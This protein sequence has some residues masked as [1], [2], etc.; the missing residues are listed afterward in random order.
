[1]GVPRRVDVGKT[2]ADVPE[3]AEA[4]RRYDIRSFAAIVVPGTCQGSIQWLCLYQPERELRATDE[5][6]IWLSHFTRHMA[7]ALRVNQIV[8]APPRPWSSDEGVAAVEASTGKLIRADDTFLKSVMDEWL[9]FDGLVLPP[10]V[11]KLWNTVNHKFVFIGRRTRLEGHR[12]GELVYVCARQVIGSGRLTN[13]QFEVASL[14]TQGLGSKEIARRL[15]ISHATVRNHLA[16][17][18]AT[19]GVHEKMAMAERMRTLF[20]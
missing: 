9:G 3:S 5:Q 6:L 13:R 10:L 15:N 7:E 19:L 12:C 1:M 4:G 2:Y 16:I 14:Y 18:Y 11:R 20:S 17:A 8:H